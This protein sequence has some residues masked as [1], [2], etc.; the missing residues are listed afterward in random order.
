MYQHKVVRNFLE[1]EK[2]YLW[3]QHMIERKT[4][5]PLWDNYYVSDTD[6]KLF[7]LQDKISELLGLAENWFLDTY[8]VNNLVFDRSHTN[9]M[10]AGSRLPVHK[11]LLNKENP[12]MGPGNAYVCLIF[13]TDDYEGGN[14]VFPEQDVSLRLNAGDAIFF[15][16]CLMSHGSTEVTGGTR[17]TI[18]NHFFGDLP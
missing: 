14:I 15:P 12:A 13:L 11:D 9:I 7:D 10:E 18:A 16:G 8:K 1:K 3:A 17:V 2:C 6:P 5:H 4:K